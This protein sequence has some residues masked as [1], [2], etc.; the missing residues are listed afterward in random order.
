M[1]QAGRDRSIR[2]SLLGRSRRGLLIALA[3]LLLIFTSATAYFG[4]RLLDEKAYSLASY[5]EGATLAIELEADHQR[6]SAQL[7]RYEAQPTL[8][9]RL[10]LLQHF[11]SFEARLPLV[12]NSDTDLRL[13]SLASFL[14][15]IGEI[16]ADLPKLEADLRAL[17]AERP[18]T[19]AAVRARLVDYGSPIEELSRRVLHREYFSGS[20]RRIL[21]L[22]REMVAT[23]IVLLVAGGLLIFLL[24]Y[25][26]RLA[27]QLTAEAE[28]SRGEAQRAERRLLDAVESISE[29]FLLLDANKRVVLVNQRFYELV[30]QE[31]RSF[32]PGD[33]YRSVIRAAG[34][35]GFYGRDIAAR[36]A[37][38]RRL[39]RL[40]NPSEPFELINPDGSQIRIHEYV[41]ADGGRVSLRTEVTSLRRAERERLELQAQ[42]YRAQ[43][44]EALGRLAGGIAHE[45][46]NALMSIQ[47]YANFL[48]EDLL[49]GTAERSYAENILADSERAAVRVRQVLDFGRHGGGLLEPTRLAD[50]GREAV[51]LLTTSL[52]EAIR[53]T[54]RDDT[55]G[56]RVNADAA[57]LEQVVM[58]LCVNACDATNDAGGESGSVIAVTLRTM[59]TDGDRAKRL[60]QPQQSSVESAVP[61]VVERGS[62][63]RNRLWVGVLPPA[64]Y[65]VVEVR[66]DGSGM[67]LATLERI[68]DPFFT[69]KPQE[70]GSGLGLAA[71][72]G[73]V[74]AHGG[75]L[76]VETSP[77]EGTSMSVFLPALAEEESP[78]AKTEELPSASDEPVGQ[79]SWRVLVVDTAPEV[80]EALAVDLRRLGDLTVETA[81]GAEQALERLGQDPEI[82]LVVCDRS[83]TGTGGGDFAAE[84]R[85]LS[86]DLPLLFMART[87]ESDVV[88]GRQGQGDS[89]PLRDSLEPTALRLAVD[90]ALAKRPSAHQGNSSNKRASSNRVA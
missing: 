38:R 30:P 24:W 46:N 77:G 26:N 58:N 60:L 5:S 76:S 62:D 86:P 53:V 11:E 56:G 66:D 16:F 75:A 3:A 10:L 54:F 19:F 52:P 50:I 15:P 67:D 57:Q 41:T 81:A 51:D 80:A 47:G 65:H 43:K 64:R 12:L 27:E 82:E 36:E 22:K 28:R 37:V 7:A 25:Q 70:Q 32:G 35:L 83:L 73:I 90:R 59:T 49:P 34:S 40:E 14:T 79:S 72:Y 71:V 42:F 61:T 44:T 2:R 39:E 69:T 68:F 45:F 55:Q 84:V 23:Y 87:P 21:V 74:L 48:R 1:A 8:D 78:R 29:G 85:C 13:P 20:D 89:T 4:L 63:G 88:S 9:H 18:E 33:D 6:L 31:L 17:D